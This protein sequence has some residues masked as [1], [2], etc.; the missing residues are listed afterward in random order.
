LK[1]V[2]AQ[3]QTSDDEKRKRQQVGT[4]LVVWAIFLPG[5][6]V[7]GG[8]LAWVSPSLV[9]AAPDQVWIVRGA[10]ALLVVNLMVL[11]VAVIPQSVLQGQ[12]LGYKR[13]GLSTVVL[14]VGA[15][16][17]VLTLWAGWGL[18]GVALATIAATALSGVTYLLIVRSQVPWW[19]VERPVRGSIKGFLSL[20]W[21]FLL[22][23]LV[24]QA[25]RG[26]DV[27]VLGAVA[28]AAVVTTYSLTSFVPLSISDI[29]FMVISATMPGLA[30]FVGAGELTR[31][32][33]V[34]GETMV[35]CWLV[36]VGSAATMIVWLPAFLA[37]W[38]GPQYDAGPTATMLIC[39]MVV[40]LS[41][42]RVDSNVIDLTLRI[43][44]KVMLGL[45]SAGL[46]AGLGFWLAGPAGHG[47]DGLV[48]GFMLGRLPLTVAYP[49]LVGRLL[50]VPWTVQL[51]GLW[52]PAITSVVMFA[53][54]ALLRPFA[55]SAG[56]VS[57]IALGCLTAGVMVAFAYLVGLSRRQRYRV[58]IRALRVVRS[59]PTSTS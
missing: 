34:R 4:A 36:A 58:R 40:Q 5:T 38:V 6:A 8:V 44:G 53:G 20:S 24:M 22:W 41:L 54:A 57:L 49:V 42:I 28:G 9:H 39:V 32:A 21:W 29:V 26:S 14:F 11:G 25:M 15:G 33:R 16:L 7:I 12:N 50:A 47:I 1:W 51:R 27:I 37:H 59:G 10:A 35:L 46:S 18:M 23:N 19:G 31:A 48:V 55:A 2:V 45:F 30:G 17:T 13:L 3:A 56:W 52:R 43:R